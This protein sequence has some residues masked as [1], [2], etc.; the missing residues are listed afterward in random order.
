MKRPNGRK[1]SRSSASVK[2]HVEDVKTI[3]RLRKQRGLLSVTE[4]RKIYVALRDPTAEKH[5]GYGMMKWQ[6][7]SPEDVFP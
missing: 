4:K 3:R 5:G 6:I 1:N 2:G 7:T